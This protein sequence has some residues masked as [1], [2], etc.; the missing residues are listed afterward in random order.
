LQGWVKIRSEVRV[1]NFKNIGIRN[2]FKGFNYFQ[3]KIEAD[4]SIIMPAIFCPD[5]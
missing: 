2:N 4:K 1:S 5:K 3:A